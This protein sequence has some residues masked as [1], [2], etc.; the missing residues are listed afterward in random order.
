MVSVRRAV[1]AA[2]IAAGS[3]L[4]AQS[5]AITEGASAFA[6][7]MNGAEMTITRSG[8]SCP[9]SCIQPMIV[10][11]GI[12]TLGE[13]EVIG[14]L[15]NVVSTGAGLLIDVRMPGTFSSG[16][17]PGSVN[18]PLA[19]F[20]PDNPYRADLLSALGVSNP[21]TTPNFAAAFSLVIF[22][23]GP[24]DGAAHDAIQHLLGAGYPPSKI[25]YYRGG[26]STWSA[27]GLNI[28]VGQ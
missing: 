12:D 27:L 10:A 20:K 7:T 17:V 4:V 23:N 14:F 5:S 8:P 19:T 2:G 9:S 11:A 18:V 28:S 3:P 24:D 21:E 15:Q 26:A 25:K 6:F 22:G 16:S 13:L 1:I